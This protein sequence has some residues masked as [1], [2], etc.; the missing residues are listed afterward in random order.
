MSTPGGGKNGAKREQGKGKGG[1]IIFPPTK[2]TS[3]INIIQQLH[4]S[5]LLYM[6]ESQKDG[7]NMIPGI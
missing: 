2:V 6:C 3:P 5:T 1:D 7:M 4:Y